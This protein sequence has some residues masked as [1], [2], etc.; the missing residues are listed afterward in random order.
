MKKK[1]GALIVVVLL[2]IFLIVVKIW[3]YKSYKPVKD[4][5]DLTYAAQLLNCNKSEVWKILEQDADLFERSETTGLAQPLYGTDKSYEVEHAGI[6]DV[7]LQYSEDT[8]KGIIDRVYYYL[9]YKSFG[10]MEE[11]WEWVYTQWFALED[12][13]GREADYVTGRT[14]NPL[15]KEGEDNIHGSKW[16]AGWKVDAAE[17]EPEYQCIKVIV[18]ADGLLRVQ[19]FTV[20]E[21]EEIE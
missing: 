9:P 16:V 4:M 21:A 18:A 2:L 6:I 17:G 14:M 11:I 10:N 7:R 3:D 15:L 20:D 1:N 19:L 5:T 12:Y 8:E 13:Y